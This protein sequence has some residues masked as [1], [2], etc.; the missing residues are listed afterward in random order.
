MNIK[1][2]I[3]SLLLFALISGGAKSAWAAEKN[4]DSEAKENVV[5]TNKHDKMEVV[6][7][8]GLTEKAAATIAL[9]KVPTGEIKKGELEM[10]RGIL[11]W[12]FEIAMPDTPLCAEVE[13]NAVT[14]EVVCLEIE[15]PKASGKENKAEAKKSILEA[16]AK[17]SE[18]SARE[19]AMNRV[20]DG[21]IKTGELEKENGR[22]IWSFDIARKD[23][24]DITEVEVDAN[25]GKV[26]AVD[27]ETLAEQS[28]EIEQDK[29]KDD[30]NNKEEKDE[31]D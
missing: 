26:L 29:K 24:K 9:A 30:R 10:E 7:R 2:I 6:A 27:I 22:L 21:E 20:P 3:G 8:A 5:A 18:A 15:A 16:M 1:N 25:T 14:G 23:S 12:S 31:K 19:I 13:V 11:M 17:I 28:K 4:E